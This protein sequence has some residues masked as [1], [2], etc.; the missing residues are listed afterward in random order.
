MSSRHGA[1]K[2]PWKKTNRDSPYQLLKAID[3]MVLKRYVVAQS[4][5]DDA[6]QALEHFN[7]VIRY[8]G[9][10]PAN[11]PWLG[12][13]N[14]QAEILLCLDAEFGFTPSA[15]VRIG[16]LDNPDDDDDEDY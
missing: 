10:A 16:F 7:L 4:I 5:Y 12:I 11:N 8:P 2:K 9:G 15:R 14:R 6:K 1:K 13:L 3:V